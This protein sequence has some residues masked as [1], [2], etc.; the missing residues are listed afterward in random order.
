MNKGEHS[1]LFDNTNE[2]LIVKWKDNAN[3]NVMNNFGKVTPLSNARQYDRKEKKALQE[4]YPTL[5][6][7][8]MYIWVGLIC[9]IML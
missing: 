8:I 6:N 1:A 7:S 9:M 4:K 3:V 5:S 2:I